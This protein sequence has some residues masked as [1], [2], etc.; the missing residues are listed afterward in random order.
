MHGFRRNFDNKLVTTV[1]PAADRAT[2]HNNTTSTRQVAC[3]LQD[4]GHHLVVN[5]GKASWYNAELLSVRAI[6]SLSKSVIG[7]G[8]SNSW[9]VRFILAA[10]RSSTSSFCL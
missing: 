8:A 7:V 9:G 10:E 6:T 3:S 4:L 2:R 1:Q 5:V